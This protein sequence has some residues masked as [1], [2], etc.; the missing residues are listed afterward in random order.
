MLIHAT[1]DQLT[2][3]MGEQPDLD[4]NVDAMLRK[5]SIMVTSVT[6]RDWF[7]VQDNGMFADDDL[8]EAMAD[9]TCAQVEHWLN[10][11][12]NPLA[13]GAQ[14]DIVASSGVDG[15]SVTFVAPTVADLAAATDALCADSLRILRNAGLATAVVW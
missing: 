3:F 8:R 13:G 14:S 1:A 10:A 9:A 15:G 4:V 2:T 12:I 5:A 11:D 7:P 6:R